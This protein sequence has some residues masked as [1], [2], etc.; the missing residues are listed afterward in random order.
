MKE[1]ASQEGGSVG[2]FA[3]QVDMLKTEL[4][5]QVVLFKSIINVIAY[6]QRTLHIRST[7]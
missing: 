5:R 4:I 2:L 6:L 7:G 1:C 3:Y